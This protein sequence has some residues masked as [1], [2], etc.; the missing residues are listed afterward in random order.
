MK[1]TLLMGKT[2]LI[3]NVGESDSIGKVKDILRDKFNLNIKSS[4]EREDL[5]LHVTYAG[6]RLQD[7]W[8]LSDIGILPGSTLTCNL[9]SKD[10]IFL[11]VFSTFNE[12]YYEF[13]EPINCDKTTVEALKE[14]V[15]DE[16]GI[17]VSA[18][19]MY[20]K[21]SRVEMFDPKYLS[22][23]DVRSGD[24]VHIDIWDGMTDFM[25]S[26]FAGDVT[27]TMDSIVDFHEYPA[28]YKYQLRVALFIAAFQGNIQLAAQLLKVG[29]RC[30][31][32]IGEHPARDWCKSAAAHPS[33]LRTPAHAA[34]Q[35]GR[36][37]C[38][39][40]FVHHNR[41]CILSR[42][43]LGRTPT[44]LARR[45]GQKECFK[46][47]VAEQFRKLQYA[48][49]N[50]SIY[51]KVRKWCDRAKDHRQ[52]LLASRDKSARS[53][54][55]G[56]LIQVSGF[57]DSIQS[58]AS[59]LNRNK[60]GAKSQWLWPRRDELHDI[61]KYCDPGINSN[62]PPKSNYF[63]ALY[64]R[65]SY[66]IKRKNT[67]LLAALGGLPKIARDET[68]LSLAGKTGGFFVT[69]GKSSTNLQED[70]RTE[71]TLEK[72]NSNLNAK[73]E[74]TTVPRKGKSKSSKSHRSRR[75]SFSPRSFVTN[76]SKSLEYEAHSVI[77]QATGKTSKQLACASLELGET[78][79]AMGWLRR[80]QLATNCNRKTLLRSMQI[81]A[82]ER[83]RE[84]VHSDC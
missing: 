1:V 51:G 42:D 79:T 9:Q 2:K 11:R 58:S 83:R 27:D 77:E 5:I 69:Q 68:A 31:D 10:K 53:A 20:K 15:Q 67:R 61:K 6:S 78:F 63:P 82:D 59:K 28:L 72:S 36:I 81:K 54:A 84:N 32:P 40:L 23:Y 57:G 70:T 19:K 37:S 8:I 80:L 48:G 29:S 75:R 76:A 13:T 52:M 33:S 46:F 30:D 49:L 55:V 56:S 25:N 4:Q 18:F 35:C 65:Q 3:M 50:L 17:P 26:V 43:G 12:K 66:G 64:K 16:S 7:D 14:M 62:S 44:G 34:A 41:S 24:T 21:S 38:L 47:L 74:S 71:R 73:A 22:D 39:R 45:F 60:I